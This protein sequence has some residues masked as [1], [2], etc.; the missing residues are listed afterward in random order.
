MAT[1]IRLKR[2]GAKKAASYRIVVI[3]SREGSSGA[4]IERLG[5]YNPRTKPSLIE[6]DAPR[7]IHW[8][9]EG[10]QPSD[11]VRS[12]LKKTGVWKQYH[13]GVDPATIE[14]A[15]VVV[16]PPP[17][18]RG[19]S[20]RP[21]P[22]DRAP[23][24]YDAPAPA[25]QVEPAA[26]AEKAPAEAKAEKAPAEAKA[27][28]A[29]AEAKAEKA[30]AEAKAEKAPAEAKAEKAPAEAKAEKAPA[31]AKAE[32]APAEAK[33]EKAPAEAKAEAPE[34]AVAEAE[35]AEKS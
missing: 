24:T 14:E 16:G 9:R 5:R 33:A 32:K 15:M 20:Q 2:T 26:E 22:T 19:T 28:K 34:E 27:E 31:E 12:L 8:L 7:A 17:G 18:K 3:D 1:S 21:P 6:V 4:P 35:D 25:P 10:A 23:K 30:P 13:D 11:S 29:P